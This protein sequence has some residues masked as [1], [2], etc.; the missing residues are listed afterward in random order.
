MAIVLFGSRARGDARPD[1]DWDLL[2]VAGGLPS[3]LFE[4]RLY[5]KRLLPCTWRGSVSIVARTPAE[6]EAR[7]SS[8]YLDIAQDGLPL[9]DPESYAASR[10]LAVRRLAERLGLDR[11]ATG[12]GFAWEWRQ[13][14]GDPEALS[15]EAADAF[16]QQ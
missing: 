15:W 16:A 9:Y 4:R 2:V 10:L 6:F 8:L 5:L 11:Q 7:L 13:G 1:S 14:R 12:D 3:R